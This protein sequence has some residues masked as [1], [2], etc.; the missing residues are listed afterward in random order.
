[1]Q[2]I[3]RLD[4]AISSRLAL[5]AGPARFLALLAAHSGDSPF[6][7]AGGAVT[8]LWGP[9][10]Y[11]PLAWRA[12]AGT[13][14]GAL[15]ATLLKLV[16]RRR[17]PGPSHAAL[18]SS[19]DTH[20][21]PSGHATRAGCV[22]MLMAPLLPPWGAGLLAL[23]AVLVALARVGLQV[24]YFLDVAGGLLIGALLGLAALPLFP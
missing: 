24:H 9:A 7:L 21:F 19:F 12:L 10:A 13:V 1:M 6:W 22:V 18:Y 23:W 17:R 8:L 11:H 2:A 15:V 16:F 20:S 14:T 4:A 3:Y 5:S